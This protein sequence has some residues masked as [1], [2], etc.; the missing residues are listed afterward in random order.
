MI[1]AKSS[2]SI[3]GSSRTVRSICIRGSDPQFTTEYRN[4]NTGR[5]LLTKGFCEYTEALFTCKNNTLNQIYR[6]EDITLV[7]QD[8]G[9]TGIR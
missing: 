5:E 9:L 1:L 2:Y 8:Y 7:Y 4:S 6:K 3:A